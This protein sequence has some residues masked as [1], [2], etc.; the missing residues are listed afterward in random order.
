MNR[1]IFEKLLSLL[2]TC[3]CTRTNEE[4]WRIDGS[5]NAPNENGNLMFILLDGHRSTHFYNSLLETERR[6]VDVKWK[7]V[8]IY[9]TESTLICV[10][11][12]G[13]LSVF[14][15]GFGC[16]CTETMNHLIEV[17]N[18]YASNGVLSER[19]MLIVQH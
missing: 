19:N 2:D 1:V 5:I 11:L 4:H 13:L 8:N 10:Q 14:V 15:F 9:E 7:K 12:L 18:V 6:G 17:L 3:T 16:V